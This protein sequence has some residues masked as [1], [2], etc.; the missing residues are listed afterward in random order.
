MSAPRN[1]GVRSLAGHE[2]PGLFGIGQRETE[3]VMFEP[4]LVPNSPANPFDFSRAG[5]LLLWHGNCNN[6]A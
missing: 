6:G 2:P 1:R 4:R 3:A 5:S